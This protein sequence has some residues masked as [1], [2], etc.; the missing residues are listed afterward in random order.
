MCPMRKRTTC[1]LDNPAMH[2]QLNML[3]RIPGVL[4][5]LA[6]IALST[7]VVSGQ[8]GQP[9]P[10][11]VA[12]LFI[13]NSY[14]YYNDLPGILQSMAVQ[15]SDTLEVDV[16]SVVE[17]GARLSTHWNRKTIE[18]I[19]RGDWDYVV[20]QEQSLAPLDIR[21]QF[22][23]YGKR[24]AAEIRAVKATPVLYVTWS[25]EQRPADQKHLDDAY[26]ELAR[27]TGAIVVPVGAVWQELR[28]NRNIPSLYADDGSHPTPMGSYVAA[29]TFYRVLFGKSS[30]VR[31]GITHGL[32]PDLVRTIHRSIEASVTPAVNNR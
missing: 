16:Q 11:R 18:L 28:T 9:V 21:D 4:L 25:R 26:A 1:C 23:D 24:F 7:S 29:S 3:R 10:R 2:H 17:G 27:A 22:L 20:L 8:A 12:I 13:G 15:D 6:F 14:T 19:R 30:P 5:L 31:A 32:Q